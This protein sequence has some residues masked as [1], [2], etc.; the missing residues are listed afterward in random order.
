MRW[1][2]GSSSELNNGRWYGIVPFFSEWFCFDTH[3]TGTIM[4]LCM[5]SAITAKDGE[6]DGTRR[7]A[8]KQT[9]Q[10]NGQAR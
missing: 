5:L 3:K 1:S 4:I 6:G 7:Q 10:R 2:K 9:R 8:A